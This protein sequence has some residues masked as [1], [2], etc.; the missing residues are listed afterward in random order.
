M[1]HLHRLRSSLL[2]LSTNFLLSLS[3]SHISFTVGGGNALSL[4]LGGGRGHSFLAFTFSFVG[5]RITS[6]SSIVMNHCII[7]FYGPLTRI[8]MI[9]LPCMTRLC[10][11]INLCLA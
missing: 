3:H 2:S 4:N 9:V 11:L 8:G 5:S 10:H 1:N 6:D 7:S